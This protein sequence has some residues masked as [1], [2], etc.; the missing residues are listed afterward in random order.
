MEITAAVVNEAGG[1]FDVTDHLVL[2]DPRADEVVVKLVATGVCR[3]DI[4]ISQ[5][6]NVPAVLGHEGAGT[7]VE[8]GAGVTA[9]AVGDRVI[10]SYASCGSCSRC[11]TGDQAYCVQMFQLNFSGSRADGSKTIHTVDG[12]AISGNFFGQ[13]SFAT[14]ALA[15]ERDVVRVPDD[16]DDK[17]FRILGPLGCGVQTG[18]GAVLNTFKPVPGSSIVI[19]GA[20][21]VGLSA[22]MGAVVAHARTIIAIDVVPERLD[23]ALELGAT[24]TI[25]GA[26]SDVVEQVRSLTGGGAAYAFDTSG[27]AKVIRDLVDSTR[28]GGTVGLVAA[29]VPGAEI[30]LDHM[31]MINGPVIRGILQGD[32]IPQIFLPELIALHQA[33]G[34]PFD[35]LI[36]TYAF[37]DIQQAIKDSETGAAVKAVL[38]F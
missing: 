16:V 11:R 25:N 35:K 38:T 29:G 8:V 1:T 12:A 36:T 21:A 10:M 2:D 28:P 9:V 19:A 26:D 32:S 7:V 33:G 6:G 3:T 18:A 31:G 22:V 15:R 30:A 27:H 17:L 37:A 23:L 20:G 5:A 34:F 24:H 14:Y 4:H 13:S